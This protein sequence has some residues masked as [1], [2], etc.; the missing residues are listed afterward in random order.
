MEILERQEWIDLRKIINDVAHEYSFNID[1]LVDSLN[2]IY[3]V[4]SKLVS[5]YDKF[6]TYC[7]EKF[8]FVRN[9]RVLD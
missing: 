8:E 3:A 5:I 9:S 2:D 6:Y 7:Q 1:E 4:K